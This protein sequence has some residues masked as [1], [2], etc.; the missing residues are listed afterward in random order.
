MKKLLSILFVCCAC[1]VYAQQNGNFKSVRLVNVADSS[2]IAP[3]NSTI[4]Y[5]EQAKTL[6]AYVNN[7]WVTV[8]DSSH[9]VSPTGKIGTIGALYTADS[10]ANLNAFTS[11]GGT[12]TVVSNKI[13]F[14]GGTDD[15][16]KGIYVTNTK[17]QLDKWTLQAD[18][19]LTNLTAGRMV[20][21]GL[22][23]LATTKA[24]ISFHI[25]AN[26]NVYVANGGASNMVADEKFIATMSPAPILN[27]TYRFIAKKDSYQLVFQIQDL[28][29]T[30]LPTILT[31]N[32][33]PAFSVGN[34]GAPCVW[35][36]G[37]TFT[38]NNLYYSGDDLINPNV[39]L[40]GDS[41]TSRAFVANGT[42]YNELL[43][44]DFAGVS[45]Y[46]GGGDV[47]GDYLQ[48]L[49]GELTTIKAKT[50]LIS[51]GINDIILGIPIATTE[52]NLDSIYNTL[53]ANGSTVYFLLG[54][55]TS[56]H[57]QSVLD[58]WMVANYP[59]N[60]IDTSLPIAT[61]TDLLHPSEAG[62]F[63]IY[64]MISQS[65]KLKAYGSPGIF[66]INN[67]VPI[68]DSRGVSTT[69]NL[70]FSNGGAAG[71][72]VFT[73]GTN[74]G[75]TAQIWGSTLAPNYTYFG[76]YS[77]GSPILAMF[78][79]YSNTFNSSAGA[80]LAAFDL[81][82]GH[83]MFG[84]NKDGQF[85]I[86]NGSTRPTANVHIKGGT[87]TAGTAPIKINA[88]TLLGVTEAGA[89]E[90]DGTHLY[91]TAANAGTRF[92][93][94]QQ[95]GGSIGTNKIQISN[96]SGGLLA[97]ALSGISG[98]TQLTSATDI[99][100]ASTATYPINLDGGSF[101]QVQRSG[102]NTALQIDSEVTTSDA[103]TIK[104]S[105][106]TNSTLVLNAVGTSTTAPSITFTNTGSGV[107]VIRIIG[108]PTSSAG[109][110]SGSIYSNA[111]IL[112]IVP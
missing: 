71:S 72:N 103:I 96:G 39:L 102:Q 48:L 44:K 57:D 75:S 94:D 97:T 108:I 20:G 11:F 15:F 77:N 54:F 40:I 100:I 53:T 37:N 28:G 9:N 64:E 38:V 66:Q 65:N 2:T 107:T 105:G 50:V 62:Y 101:V 41:R 24:N 7:Q 89:I 55:Y 110:S 29:T 46:A 99:T 21:I 106:A 70:S 51:L 83:Y 104:S 112:T 45:T 86:A 90:N 49:A 69:G 35:N 36:L 58:A 1:I 63:R 22:Y 74:A 82:D 32:F 95:G 18:I 59:N 87:A 80:E 109:L 85:S 56:T 34:V 67:S 60:Y 14:S 30:D 10:F 8:V 52:A 31:Y 6:K 43:S 79:G 76:N 12:A 23:S 111:G 78:M 5:N 98:D 33:A 91:Y 81:I 61:G 16:T 68:T 4:Y 92:Q 42:A 73:V 26:G 47:T 84:V 17:T 88:G 27:H 13:N 19:K 25:Y 93:L 3:I